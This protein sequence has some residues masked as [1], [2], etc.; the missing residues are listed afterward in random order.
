MWAH[1]KDMEFLLEMVPEHIRLDFINGSQ[2]YWIQNVYFS[3]GDEQM[4]FDLVSFLENYSTGIQKI[5]L[6]SRGLLIKTEGED[7]YIQATVNVT[8]VNAWMQKVSTRQQ[9]T[10]NL[11]LCII[12]DAVLLAGF[13]YI[14]R[15]IS[16]ILEVIKERK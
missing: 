3:Y 11:L 5:N 14:N 12:I 9:L 15:G 2:E 4:E 1:E 10:T 16:M 6:D 7:P 13:R 8:E